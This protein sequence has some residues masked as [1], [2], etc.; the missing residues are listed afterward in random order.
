MKQLVCKTPGFFKMEDT[1]KPVAA[2][3]YVIAK[4]DSIGIC[5]TDIHAFKGNQAFFTYPRVLGHELSGTVVETAKDSGALL[6][7]K[8]VV[9]PVVACRKCIACRRGMPNCCTDINVIGVHSDGGMVQYLKVPSEN[10]LMVEGLS[11]ETISIIEPLAIGAHGIYRAGDISGKHVAVAGAG[12]IGIGIALQARIKGAKVIILDINESRLKYCT[13]TFGFENTVLV[14]NSSVSKI[15]E[16]TSGDFCEVVFDATGNRRALETGVG[17]M[18][19]GGKYVLVG[20]SNG[21]LMFHHPS[22]HAKES[23]ILCS[24]NATIEDFNNVIELL[25]TGKLNLGG[26]INFK[27]KFSVLMDDFEHIADPRNGVIKAVV[28]MD[29]NE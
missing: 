8:V 11:S 22:I 6:G 5:G 20:L 29:I 12:P 18:S 7:K 9:I 15:S 27:T 1:G 16:V 14:N 26:Y 19:H 21:E 3:G 10:V 4:I 28:E 2:P 17:Y 13:S 23:D 24:R 25:Q